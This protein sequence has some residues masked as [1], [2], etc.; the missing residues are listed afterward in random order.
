MRK[1]YIVSFIIGVILIDILLV[2]FISTNISCKCNEIDEKTEVE[3]VQAYYGNLSTILIDYL[4]EIYSDEKYIKGELDE[5]TYIITLR[6]LKDMG[7]DVSMFL[8]PVLTKSCDLDRTYGKAVF[9]GKSDDGLNQFT[10]TTTLHCQISK[11][12]V[13]NNLNK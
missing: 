1:I 7:K 5:D 10:Y 12:D 11:D 13:D 2:K 8:E 4:N 3:L 9:T 6:D